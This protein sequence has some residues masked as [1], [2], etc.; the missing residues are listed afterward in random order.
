MDQKTTNDPVNNPQHYADLFTNKPTQCRAIARLLGFDPANVIKY[1]WRAGNKSK[2]KTKEDLQKAVNYLNDW[3]ALYEILMFHDI[4]NFEAA[5]VLF[6]QIEEPD[7]SEDPVS[8][9]KWDIV[10]AVLSDKYR[11]NYET[12][13]TYIYNCIDS[14]CVTLTGDRV[15]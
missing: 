12:T 14:L 2:D 1:C 8:F 15:K 11:D 6:A 5:R 9:R 10:R 13:F 4:G 3:K 7:N